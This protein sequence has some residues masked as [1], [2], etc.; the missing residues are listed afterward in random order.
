MHHLAI[1]LAVVESSA[2]CIAWVEACAI[3]FKHS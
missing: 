2:P 3:G 1:A